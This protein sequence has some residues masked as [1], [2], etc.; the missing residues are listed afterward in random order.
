MTTKHTTF[1]S[2]V[3]AIL[4]IGTFLYVN[5]AQAIGVLPDDRALVSFTEPLTKAEVQT[6][7]QEHELRATAIYMVNAGLVGTHRAYEPMDVEKFLQDVQ[8]G[9]IEAM[10]KNLQTHLVFQMRD[11][12]EQHLEEDVLADESL[13]QEAR[14][15]INIK[16]QLEATIKAAREDAPVIYALE[17]IGDKRNLERL[18]ADEQVA[19]FQSFNLIEARIA[20]RRPPVPATTFQQEFIAPTLQSMGPR[21]MYQYMKTFIADSEH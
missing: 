9:T 3:L 14:S 12:I 1:I 11:F 5:R 7:L 15:L 4:A 19:T 18:R 8:A 17:V 2:I 6:L 13:Q 16:F 20:S 10:E 21:E